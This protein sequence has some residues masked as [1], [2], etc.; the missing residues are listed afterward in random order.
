MK[1]RDSGTFGQP[2]AGKY[3]PLGVGVL[4]GS[5]RE[6]LEI[7]DGRSVLPFP[8]NP[9][10]SEALEEMLSEFISDVS[11]VVNHVLPDHVVASHAP[12]SKSARLVEDAYQ[13][14]KLRDDAGYFRSHQVV[15]RGPR[16]AGGVDVT[17]AE[18]DREA[19]MSVSDLHVDAWDGGGSLGACTV[20]TCRRANEDDDTKEDGEL[21]KCRGLAVFPRKWGGRGVHVNSMVPGWNCAL[22]NVYA[23]M[24]TIARVCATIS[25]VC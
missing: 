2:A 5:G 14:P 10:E 9:V 23:D 12:L 15:I 24:R 21:L 16:S 6:S 1:E 3:V 17:N 11:A 4:T 25:G 7:G 18:M 13:Y 20:H 19:Y 8:R 22:C